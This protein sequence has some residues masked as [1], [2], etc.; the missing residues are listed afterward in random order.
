M[1]FGKEENKDEENNDVIDKLTSYIITN[2]TFGTSKNAAAVVV[3]KN[4]RNRFLWRAIFPN[5]RNM[6]SMF[7]WLDKWPILLPY[8][9]LL[10]GV[11]S[12]S[13]RRQNIAEQLNKY[14]NGDKEY[15]KELQ[16]FF[17]MCG[18]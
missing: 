10:R 8:A 17:E 12:I 14:R 18:L 6:K 11:R 5:Y 1:W 9:W 13:S 15:G 3:A 4:G 2:G 7:P 16:Q